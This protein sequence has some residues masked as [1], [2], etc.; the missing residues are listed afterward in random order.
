MKNIYL[1]LENSIEK[2]FY[3]EALFLLSSIIENETKKFI[4]KKIIMQ[5]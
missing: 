5:E 4:R 1:K 3:Y 2:N